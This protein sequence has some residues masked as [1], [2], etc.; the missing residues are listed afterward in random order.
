MDV[1]YNKLQAGINTAEAK[2]EEQVHFSI[3]VIF[4]LT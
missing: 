3:A 4:I 1:W 2:A